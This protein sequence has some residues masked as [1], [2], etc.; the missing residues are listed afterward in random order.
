MP[1]RYFRGICQPELLQNPLFLQQLL[2][3]THK[4][5]L[6]TVNDYSAQIA[7]PRKIPGDPLR[8]PMGAIQ[9]VHIQQYLLDI[10]Y[11]LL[12]AV[13]YATDWIAIDCG[14]LPEKP[15]LEIES[16]G[17]MTSPFFIYLADDYVGTEDFHLIADIKQ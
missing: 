12:T 11:L 14:F 17:A 8:P 1:R 2:G 6:K 9:K 13:P 3:K 15:F 5:L 4:D 7:Y 16:I 10:P